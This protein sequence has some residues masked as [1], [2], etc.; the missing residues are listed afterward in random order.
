MKRVTVYRLENKR[1]EGPY[2]AGGLP[3][4]GSEFINDMKETH[5]DFSHP[6]PLDEGMDFCV[7]MSN[8]QDYVFGFSSKERAESWFDGFLPQLFKIGFELKK[9]NIPQENVE[10]APS[11]LQLAFKKE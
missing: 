10:I 11:K 2:R 6:T 5:R 3:M 7:F 4:P 8:N 9:F 1:G